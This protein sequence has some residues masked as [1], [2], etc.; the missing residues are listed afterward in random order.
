M[1]MR[2]YVQ[3]SGADM[4]ALTVEPGTPVLEVL[5]RLPGVY[6][7]PPNRWERAVEWIAFSPPGRVVRPELREQ[8]PLLPDRSEWD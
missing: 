3:A 6:M 8:H 5:A 2:I 7:R 4:P 1:S